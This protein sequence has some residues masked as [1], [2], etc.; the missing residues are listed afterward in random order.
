MSGSASSL[1]SHFEKEI[2][3]ANEP[4][5]R[6]ERVWTPKSDDSYNRQTTKQVAGGPPPKKS[7][8]DLP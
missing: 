3:R 7:I 1:K 5:G 6:K 4:A 8:S 2:E